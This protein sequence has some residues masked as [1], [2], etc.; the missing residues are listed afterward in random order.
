PLVSG[1]AEDYALAHGL[2]LD[3]V[4]RG[5]PFRRSGVL[6]T[7]DLTRYPMR[8]PDD[9]ILLACPTYNWEIV[10]NISP[11]QMAEVIFLS[12]T[13]IDE[14]VRSSGDRGLI[15][16]IGCDPEQ[17]T[18][19]PFEGFAD[20]T[21]SERI[22]MPV[23][24][25]RDEALHNLVDSIVRTA[26]RLA[27]DD[28]KTGPQMPKGFPQAYRRIV[29]AAVDAVLGD[30]PW[31]ASIYRSSPDGHWGD[32]DLVPISSGAP[33]CP[34]I[35]PQVY[36]ETAP[37]SVNLRE[38]ESARSAESDEDVA[39]VPSG[40]TM[41]SYQTM[42]DAQRE[43]YVSWRTRARKGDYR[44]TDS[45]Y[46]WLYCVELINRDDSPEEVQAELE[47][48]ADAFFEA[49]PP[50]LMAAAADHALLH[51]FDVPP[52]TMERRCSNHL[53]HIKIASRPPG[54]MSIRLA[55]QYAEYD[56]D[57][58]V[59]H[60]PRLYAEAFTLAVRAVDSRMETVYHRRIVDLGGTAVYTTTKRLYQGLWM[61]RHPVMSLDF[62]NALGI[63]RLTDMMDG[64]LRVTI[65]T[66]NRRL[67][68]SYPRMPEIRAEYAAAVEGAVN[69]Y[70]DRREAADRARRAREEADSIVIDRDAVASAAADLEAVRGMMAVGEDIQEEISEE[71]PEPEPEPTGWDALIA[72]LDPVELSYLVASLTNRGA[73]E[74]TL[75]G[76]G[77]RP[78]EVEGAVNTK[79]MD[80]VGDTVIE[81]GKAFAEYAGEISEAL[82]D[83]R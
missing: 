9:D 35:L 38:L 34:V 24:G 14:M 48:A 44:D 76:T 30:E 29:A 51:G 15:R 54:R 53:A 52:Q 3:L 2:P 65:R 4:P 42:D 49:Q 25:P 28:G 20:F 23:V 80:A 22:Q 82:R 69:G 71:P 57:R 43:F 55:E 67:G 13:G 68:K 16:A 83:L 33:D 40:R 81:Y 60:D 79:A 8:R 37:P 63:K 77:R 5:R 31:D 11:E 62:R 10:L 18:V 47:R 19:W 50:Y 7:W 27:R 6:F 64:I 66:V 1:L 46:L 36:P 78:A 45:G 74:H 72:S 17:F 73:G 21:G 26:V 56:A 32:D 70:M 12:L 59:S 41:T 75:E 39:Y 58:Y 61:P